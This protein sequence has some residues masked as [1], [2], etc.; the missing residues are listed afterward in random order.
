MFQ[1]AGYA[2]SQII[3]DFW[4]NFIFFLCANKYIDTLLYFLGHC[5]SFMGDL[6]AFFKKKNVLVLYIFLD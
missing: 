5:T 6:C 2:A 1:L 4:P 3:F